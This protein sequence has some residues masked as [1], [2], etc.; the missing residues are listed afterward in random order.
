MNH[1]FRMRLGENPDRGSVTRSASTPPGGLRI[2]HWDGL[3]SGVDSIAQTSKSAVSRA[4][5]ALKWLGLRPRKRVSKPAGRRRIGRARYPLAL[6]IGKS[7]IQQTGK[8]ALLGSVAL[9]TA[10]Q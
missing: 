7:A 5:A 2:E 10:K 6:P 3:D 8:S 4:F 1:F 9:P